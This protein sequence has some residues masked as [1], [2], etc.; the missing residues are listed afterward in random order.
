[1]KKK[2]WRRCEAR[3]VKKECLR[4]PWKRPTVGE[5]DRHGPL[6]GT[7]TES[8]WNGGSYQSHLNPEGLR[9]GGQDPPH[10]GQ[11]PNETKA[12]WPG[13]GTR[14]SKTTGAPTI[15]MCKGTGADAL[16]RKKN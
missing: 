4:L 1:M 7:C 6:L 16:R 11:V 5:V 13:A 10:F 14:S 3:A 12:Q 15:A 8:R 9:A 2:G